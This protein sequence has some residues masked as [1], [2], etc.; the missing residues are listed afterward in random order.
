MAQSAPSQAKIKSVVKK[1]VH[2]GIP[3]RIGVNSGSLE[4]KLLQEEG[5]P[6]VRA[7][8]RSALYNI[9]LCQEYG[10]RDLVLSIKSSHVLKTIQAY[11]EAAAQ[12]DVPLHLGLTEAG[13]LKKG[14]IRSAVALG[15]LLHQ[16]IGDTIRVSLTGFT[17]DVRREG[18]VP[19]SQ[20][21]DARLVTSGGLPA[22][23][24]G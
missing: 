23:W 6:T 15:V 22:P 21:L 16:G 14:A 24:C 9:N 17:E 11:R 1:A 4:K 10:A 7:L 2:Y 5:G 8:V 3:I 13:T 20:L 12:T 18:L 19:S